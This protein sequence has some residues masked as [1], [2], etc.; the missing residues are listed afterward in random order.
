MLSLATQTFLLLLVAF[1]LGCL[2][3]FFLKHIFGAKSA[4]SNYRVDKEDPASEMVDAPITQHAT[5]AQ[6]TENN[7][8]T[9]IDPVDAIAASQT[10]EAMALKQE[11]PSTSSKSTAATSKSGNVNG[12]SS[13]KP[14]RRIVVSRTTPL[15]NDKS[16]QPKVIQAKTK[17]SNIVSKNSQVGGKI[18]PQKSNVKINKTP[19]NPV[20]KDT[21]PPVPAAPTAKAVAT[22]AK[23]NTAATKIAQ[24]APNDDL[25]LIKGVGPQL[26][27]KLNGLGLNYFE[28]VAKLTRKR[29][30]EID[31]TLKFTGRIDP[32]LNVLH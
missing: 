14:S 1:I 11:S 26:E 4:P 12:A 23:T 22:P 16:S 20:I 17:K 8:S 10:N 25:K 3:G 6:L 21:V 15:S 13:D 2:L 24:P 28:D 18:L 5:P 19:A 32:M 9:N 7:T 29:I 31:E 30:A 27:K